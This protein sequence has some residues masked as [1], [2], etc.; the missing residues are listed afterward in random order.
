M[1]KRIIGVVILVVVVIQFFRPARNISSEPPGKDDVTVRFAPPPAV[2]QTLRT[3]CY[4]CHS[5]NTRYPW[6]A[7]VEPVGWWLANHIKDGKRHLNFSVIG[8]YS[9]KKQ[10]HVFDAISDQVTE[11]DM[12]L[13]SYTWIHRDARLTTAQIN[14]LSDWS[15][16][17]HDKVAPND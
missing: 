2:A 10:A 8:S 11:H 5:N 14:A 13:Q 4:D 9:A 16:A 1:A 17:Q 6:Y 7:N 12:P 3:A 15:D